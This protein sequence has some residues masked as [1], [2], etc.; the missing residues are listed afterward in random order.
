[1]YRV[2]PDAMY[3][4]LQ[5]PNTQKNNKTHTHMSK[6]TQNKQKNHNN[7]KHTQKAKTIQ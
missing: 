7:A 4:S 5:M 6:T 2:A 1:M 3:T